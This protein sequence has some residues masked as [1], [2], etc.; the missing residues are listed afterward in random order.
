MLF[1]VYNKNYVVG[2]P[3]NAN[4]EKPYVGAFYFGISPQ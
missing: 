4:Q 1:S 2:L 3:L